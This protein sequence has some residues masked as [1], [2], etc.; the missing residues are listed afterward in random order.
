[1]PRSAAAIPAAVAIAPAMPRPLSPARRAG[2]SE[3]QKSE[4]PSCEP[5]PPP[6]R[7][8]SAGC[9]SS[10]RSLGPPMSSPGACAAGCARRSPR[11]TAACFSSRYS[12]TASPV[13]PSVIAVFTTPRA[14]FEGMKSG[15]E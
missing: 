14:N 8:P 7:R 2:V 6:S 3:S 4:N 5:V 9:G 15:V 1:M 11:C 12:K 13:T 10:F